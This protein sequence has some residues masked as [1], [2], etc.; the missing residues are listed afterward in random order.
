MSGLA[1]DAAMT[2]RHGPRCVICHR[3]GHKSIRRTRSHLC[4]EHHELWRELRK[5]CIRQALDSLVW[6]LRG[7]GRR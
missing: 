2:G 4:V 3:P 5:G 6:R 7:R 1:R